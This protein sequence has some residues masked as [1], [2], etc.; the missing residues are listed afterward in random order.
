MAGVFYAVMR[1]RLFDLVDEVWDDG[2]ALI[3]RN[4][5]MEA[6]ID[7]L[8]IINVND[9]TSANWPRVTLF[10]REPCELGDSVSFHPKKGKAPAHRG[11]AI[12]W[13]LMQRVD[14][15]RRGSQHSS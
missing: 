4:R 1:K 6:R 3:V 12:A 5:G 14:A 11:N 15:A 7:L 10:L 8:N 13:D 9:M 2:D